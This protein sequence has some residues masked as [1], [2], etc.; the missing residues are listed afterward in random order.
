MENRFCVSSQGQFA[1]VYASENLLV[2]LYSQAVN[3]KL[4][5][6]LKGQTIKA[7]NPLHPPT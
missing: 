5:I 6:L 2:S 4:Q 1:T 7:K 3:G